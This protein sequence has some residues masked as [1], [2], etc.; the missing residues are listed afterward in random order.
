MQAGDDRALRSTQY[1]C[2]N[3]ISEYKTF[4]RQAH[5]GWYRRTVASKTAIVKMGLFSIH[6]LQQ[7]YFVSGGATTYSCNAQ[8][9]RPCYGP[10]N[11]TAIIP[12]PHDR[13]ERDI[14]R[15]CRGPSV[16][17]SGETFTQQERDAME[18]A[19]EQIYVVDDD[20]SVR[21]GLTMSLRENGRDAYA[22]NVS[23]SFCHYSQAARST[24]RRRQYLALHCDHIMK[25]CSRIHFPLL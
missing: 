8:H 25:K 14:Q 23:R 10:V 12:C 16:L 17:T 1:N 4:P 24:S 3:L 13:F 2:R 9:G 15:D 19:S 18:F 5:P 21:E 7:Y 20:R 22:F 11:R 6:L